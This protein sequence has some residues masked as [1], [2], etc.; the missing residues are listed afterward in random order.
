MRRARKAARWY[1]LTLL[2]GACA[3]APPARRAPSTAP[4]PCAQER[5]RAEKLAVEGQLDRALRVI[6]AAD[7]RC[8][9][10]RARSELVRLRLERDLGFFASELTDEDA[11]AATAD[12]MTRAGADRQRRFDRILVGLERRHR[13]EA[14]AV[15][16][17]PSVFSRPFRDRWVVRGAAWPSGPAG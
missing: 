12:A 14:R 13:A 5:L 9:A 8:P 11:L 3:P 15:L 17:E 10:S 2:L 7:A 4:T 16:F 1:G 6:A